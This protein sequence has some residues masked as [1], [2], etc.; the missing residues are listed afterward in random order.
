MVAPVVTDVRVAPPDLPRGG[1]VPLARGL[2]A[3]PEGVRWA[4]VSSL[5][6][7]NP[8]SDIAAAAGDDGFTVEKLMKRIAEEGYDPTRPITVGTDG[9]TVVAGNHRL[10]AV[11]RLG[12]DKIPVQSAPDDPAALLA[13]FAPKEG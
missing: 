4:D 8:A 9:Q 7:M 1:R 10:L 3:L 5:R 12:Y 11:R 13:L 2:A 6:T